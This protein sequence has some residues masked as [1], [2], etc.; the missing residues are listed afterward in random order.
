MYPYLRH[1]LNWYSTVSKIINH[2]SSWSD[3][4][5]CF[6][7]ITS[8]F[9]FYFGYITANKTQLGTDGANL[10]RFLKVNNLVELR[11]FEKCFRRPKCHALGHP[12]VKLKLL[13]SSQRWETIIWM[14]PIFVGGC[15]LS[16]FDLLV[17][18][19]KIRGKTILV[20]KTAD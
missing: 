18:S 4:K 6:M 20:I 5:V 9:N 3:Q 11:Y 16:H 12:W 15:N 17:V 19:D 7:K 10:S 14:N 8:N 1:D 2:W 13:M